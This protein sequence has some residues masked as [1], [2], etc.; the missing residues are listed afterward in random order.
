MRGKTTKQIKIKLH[1]RHIEEK[2]IQNFSQPEGKRQTARLKHRLED[3]TKMHLQEI[4]LE[5]LV[6]ARVQW[7]AL[8]NTVTNFWVL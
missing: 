1:S 2:C 7:Q 8:A 5:H 6:W 3:T 4:G